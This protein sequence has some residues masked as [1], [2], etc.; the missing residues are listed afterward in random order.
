MCRWWLLAVAVALGLVGPLSAQVQFTSLN[1]STGGKT[2][3]TTPIVPQ[4]VGVPQ[5]LPQM[6]VSRA[7]IAPQGNARQFDFS[8]LLPNFS[9]I[10]GR[11]PIR[12]GHSQVP[13]PNYG[14]LGQKKN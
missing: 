3:T 11:W 8:K 12:P 4:T 6:N 2:T 1:A 9:F 7:L 10:N 14:T 5:M 13:R